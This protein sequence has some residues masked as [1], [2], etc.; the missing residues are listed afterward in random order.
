MSVSIPLPLMMTATGAQSEG[1]V[2][3]PDRP[4]IEQCLAGDPQGFRELYQRHQQ[5][6]RS[7][8]FQLCGAT[9]AL[10][11]LVQ[12]VFL[13]AWKGLRGLKHEAKFST[14]LYRITWNVACDYRRQLGTRKSRH[15]Q[16]LHNS[17]PL[18]PGPDLKQL[19]YEDL[20]QRGLAQLSLDYRSVLVMHDLQGLAQKE[21]A[22]ILRIPVGT[23]KSRLFRARG[24]LRTYFINA[25][26][27]L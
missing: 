10:D 11:D 4:V 16:Y 23:V 25:G 24:T 15:H 1:K 5:R 9:I 26:V 18:T 13:R 27:S 19:H 6:V 21:I 8:L 20:V 14:W 3:D 17:E 12:E 22:E 7:L 2:V